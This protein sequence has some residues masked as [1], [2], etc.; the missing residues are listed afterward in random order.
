ML[1]GKNKEF[2]VQ[3]ILPLA[4]YHSEERP[5]YSLLFGA[6]IGTQRAL[7]TTDVLVMNP[8][9][10]AMQQLAWDHGCE[11]SVAKVLCLRT[12]VFCYQPCCFYVVGEVKRLIQ[13]CGLDTDVLYV[14]AKGSP[15]KVF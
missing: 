6:P 12:D 15:G 9:S 1:L 7:W 10:M 8:K 2:Y 5:D 11:Y 14:S 3:H 4:L 13:N